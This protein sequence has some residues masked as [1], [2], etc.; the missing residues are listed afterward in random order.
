LGNLRLAELDTVHKTETDI[1]SLTLQVVCET[2]IS[3]DAC[4]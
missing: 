4:I 3:K 1:A 2:P